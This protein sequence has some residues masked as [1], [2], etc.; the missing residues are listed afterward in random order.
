MPHAIHGLVKSKMISKR[1]LSALG[2]LFFEDGHSIV[3]TVSSNV[4]KSELFQGLNDAE[5]ARRWNLLHKARGIG[6][7]TEQKAQQYLARYSVNTVW[8][9][10]LKAYLAKPKR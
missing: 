1:E 8:S 2:K 9:K 7:L 4:A 5:R 6:L 3:H 10:S